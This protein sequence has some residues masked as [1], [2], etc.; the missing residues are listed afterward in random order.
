M[1]KRQ[2]ALQRDEVECVD[3]EVAAGTGQLAQSAIT[4]KS[5]RAAGSGQ[6][7]DL[8]QAVVDHDIGC[9]CS[10]CNAS[11]DLNRQIGGADGKVIHPDKTNRLR[12]GLERGKAAPHHVVGQSLSGQCQTK[13]NALQ[14]QAHGI[15]RAAIQSSKG[16]NA[17]AANGEQ[18]G[19]DQG[20]HLGLTFNIRIV[21]IIQVESFGALFDGKT[22][23]GLEKAE[24]V[25]IHIA[26]GAQQL[27]L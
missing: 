16:I 20:G 12:C 22:T 9:T 1:F 18:I 27:A 21:A 17:A 25:K 13:I 3:V 19:R 7:F 23:A 15:G 11:V 24:H 8:A 2:E 10:A 4:V 14:G 26:G 5:N 6:H